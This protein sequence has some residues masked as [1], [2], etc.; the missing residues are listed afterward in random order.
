MTVL[1]RAPGRID[2]DALAGRCDGA[3]GPAGPCGIEADVVQVTE[4]VE[5]AHGPDEYFTFAVMLANG[6]DAALPEPREQLRKVSNRSWQPRKE[7]G[8]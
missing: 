2:E 3:M 8:F 1:G 7:A 4:R 6:T 5:K